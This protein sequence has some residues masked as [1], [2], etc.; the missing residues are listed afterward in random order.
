MAER[1]FFLFF[2]GGGALSFKSCAIMFR[3]VRNRIKI[4][5]IWLL[6]VTAYLQYIDFMII[7]VFEYVSPVFCGVVSN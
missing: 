3:I 5:N 2:F 4:N 1:S 6:M 7:S